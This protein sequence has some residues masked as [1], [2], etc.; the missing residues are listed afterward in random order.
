MSRPYGWP[1][2]V[3]GALVLILA[4]VIAFSVFSRHQGMDLVVDDYYEAELEYQDQIDRER[5]ADELGQESP[6]VSLESGE[7][8]QVAIVFPGRV[9]GDAPV[10]GEVHLYRPS[11]AN[12]DRKIPLALD[13]E[14]RQL[15]D[16][17][18]LAEGLWIVKLVWTQSG[19]EFFLEQRLV[20][21]AGRS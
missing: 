6:S 21:E 8:S 13:V 16:V 11:A 3:T 17:E 4:G 20:L 2:G 1:L 5:R 12:L 18:D 7:K 14:G 9:A 15:I 19:E 10:A